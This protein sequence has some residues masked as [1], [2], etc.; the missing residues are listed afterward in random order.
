MLILIGGEK[1]GSGKS[2]IAQNFAT[3][4]RRIEKEV[5]LVDCDPQKTTSSWIQ[6][7]NENKNLLYIECIQLYGNILKS[8]EQLKEKYKIIIVDC[9]GQDSKALRSALVSCSHALFPIRPK[10]RDLKTLPHLEELL[11]EAKITNNNIRY[12]TVINQAPNLPSQM[13]RILDAKVIC[14]N[15]N[16]P[17]LDS[18]LF[19]RN[20]YD[21]SEESGSS[22]YEE[23]TD[24]K[25]K[26]ELCKVVNEF[27]N[28]EIK[29]V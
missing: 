19:Y 26:E 8:L 14:H 13:Q 15:W 12:A 11:S 2:C 20:I 22:V 5:L 10:R 4:L 6:E 24:L 29:N 17:C 18:I 7:R 21:D 9:G 25:A 27:L 3:I 1:G 23:N 16:I 28:I